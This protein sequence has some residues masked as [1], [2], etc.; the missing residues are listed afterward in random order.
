MSKDDDGRPDG[1]VSRGGIQRAG[2]GSRARRMGK[3]S[4]PELTQIFPTRKP[5]VH[6][7]GSR[8][9]RPRPH[10]GLTPNQRKALEVLDEHGM[11]Q[12]E[13]RELTGLGGSSCAAA[14]MGLQ[15]KDLAW[16]EPSTGLWRKGAMTGGA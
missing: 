14:L 5:S 12:I 15:A 4:S 10:V 2:P 7:V 1:M 16:R 8:A 6:G 3:S 11:C 9:D 13:V